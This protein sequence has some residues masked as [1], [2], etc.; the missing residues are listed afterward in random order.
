MRDC[1]WMSEW[2]LINQYSLSSILSWGLLP[3]GWIWWEPGRVKGGSGGKRCGKEGYMVRNNISLKSVYLFYHYFL[4]KG[5]ITPKGCWTTWH[6]LAN[7]CFL[8]L[9]SISCATQCHFSALSPGHRV[10]ALCPAPSAAGLTA[11]VNSLRSWLSCG[12]YDNETGCV[13]CPSCFPKLHAF[14]NFLINL[15]NI[16]SAMSSCGSTIVLF[17]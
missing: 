11:T 12:F 4:A 17:F 8:F 14:T 6:I 16:Q 1:Q 2:I 9:P 3:M 15:Q 7:L 5:N 13:K 10:P